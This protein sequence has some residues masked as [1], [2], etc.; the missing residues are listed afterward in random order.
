MWECRLRV[1]ARP[2]CSYPWL[3]LWVALLPMPGWKQDPLGSGSYNPLSDKAGGHFLSGRVQHK[4]EGVGLGVALGVLWLCFVLVSRIALGTR[5]S[6]FCGHLVEK[7]RQESEGRKGCGR[8]RIQ[9]LSPEPAPL[10]AVLG[11]SLFSAP[12]FKE[13]WPRPRPAT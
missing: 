11:G 5:N 12:V 4:H 6:N 10:K 1:P 7:G 13:V 9:S 8:L 3:W 2:A